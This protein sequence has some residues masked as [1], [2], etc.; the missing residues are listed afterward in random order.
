MRKTILLT[1]AAS[2]FLFGSCDM[3]RKMAGR[4]TSEELDRRKTE[5][6]RKQ[7][8]IALQKEAQKHLSD[9]LAIVDSIRM[10]KGNLLRVSD[11]G[12]VYTTD[13]DHRYYVIVGTFKKKSNLDAMI[14]RVSDAGLLP[15][16]IS[17]K[18]GMNAVGVSPAE[19][20]EDA[21][22]S[23]RAVVREDFCPAD[24]WILENR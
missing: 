24:A 7:K 9:S 15:V 16:S 4:P 14:T 17:F 10:S 19:N 2:L 5:I 8:E 21:F 22:Y 18:N 13:L 23:L 3:F 20:L 6:L 12:G 1:L 11:L